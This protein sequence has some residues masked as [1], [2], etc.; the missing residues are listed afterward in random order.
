M[1][2]LD[3]EARDFATPRNFARLLNCVP[4]KK[5]KEIAAEQGYDFNARKLRF[6]PHLRAWVLF[7]LTNDETM[8]DMHAVV[9]D[10]PL[11]RLNGAG[12]DISVGGL[13]HA[14]ATRPYEALQ[15]VL[16]EALARIEAV[17]KSKR[18]LRELSPDT[19]Q[20]IADLLE[21]AVLFDSTTLHLPAK[22]KEWAEQQAEV[23]D[24]WADV[25]EEIDKATI[26]PRRADVMVTFCG[27]AWVPTWRVIL[28]GGQRLELP[29]R[30]EV[31]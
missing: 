28:E 4:A 5:R 2:K 19:L 13:S 6:D 15:D 29:A 9:N 11:Y 24:H 26:T 18:I 14:H 10:D 7:G 21:H 16:M 12:I 25:L 31:P 1:S 23:R 8:R 22:I 20:Q 30:E 17:P 27:P 3:P